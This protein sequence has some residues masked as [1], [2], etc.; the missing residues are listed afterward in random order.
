M[1]EP[2]VFPSGVL[3]D[4]PAFFQTGTTSVVCHNVSE[5]SEGEMIYRTIAV[6][7]NGP[8]PTMATKVHA[9]DESTCV[10]T[11]I[12]TVRCWGQSVSANPSS[13]FGLPDVAVN[14]VGCSLLS[15][16]QVACGSPQQLVGGISGAT[17]LSQNVAYNVWFPVGVSMAG[18]ALGGGAVTCFGGPLGAVAVTTTAVDGVTERATSLADRG[19]PCA[20]LDDGRIKCGPL[21]QGADGWSEGEYEP[22]GVVYPPHFD[23]LTPD[24]TAVQISVG[25]SPYGDNHYCALTEA[26]TV[27]CWGDN[28]HG[29][30]GADPGTAGDVV[31]DPVQVPG[32][33]DVV[34]IAGGQYHSCART[35]GGAVW[36]WGDDTEAQLGDPAYSD[37][38]ASPIQVQGL[39][40]IGASATAASLSSGWWHSCVTTADSQLL[41]WGEVPVPGGSP[42]LQY[43]Q[44]PVPVSG[45]I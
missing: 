30:T 34:E 32:L 4:G 40:G 9:S 39:D 42:Q 41:C 36:C 43:Q 11:D 45:V 20:V 8:G 5:D 22:G 28:V 25:F 16:G 29:Q 23:G 18:C 21:A 19:G 38:S 31:F 27:W 1:A 37:Y 33:T 44:V 2:D 12:G 3:A 7:V 15:N 6:T 35:S 10:V 26:G 14:R 13:V 17:A 24:T